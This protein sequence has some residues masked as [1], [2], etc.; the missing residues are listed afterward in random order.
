MVKIAEEREKN[1][2]QGGMDFS[3]A[4]IT[5]KHGSC[6][7]E[8]KNLSVFYTNADSLLNKMSEL[9]HILNDVGQRP[10]VVAVTEYKSKTKIICSMAE[11]Q[12]QVYNMFHNMDDKKCRRGVVIY[13]EKSMQANQI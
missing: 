2:G 7:N 9:E 12:L 8:E 10:H 3:G 11:Y 1:E 4:G 6:E 13:V 5:R